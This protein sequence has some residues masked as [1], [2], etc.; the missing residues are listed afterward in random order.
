MSV[1]NT[2]HSEST[3]KKKVP[4]SVCP[5]CEGRLVDGNCETVCKG[6][7]LVIETEGIDHGPEW[8]A[9]NSQDRDRK[10]RVGAPVTNTMHDKG[11]STV[12]S[13]SDKD[14]QGNLLSGRKRRQMRRLRTWNQR[15]KTGGSR[16]QYQKQ[17]FGEIER[18]A[19]ALGLP[20]DVRET[21]CV[22]FRRSHDEGLVSGRS[23]ESVAAG[24]LHIAATMVGLP[25]SLDEITHV[26]RVARIPIARAKREII[27]E[28]ELAVQPGD[29]TAFLDRFG[30]QLEQTDET[31]RMARRILKTA[32]DEYLGSGASPVAIAASAL[33]LSDQLTHGRSVSQRAV[34]EVSGVCIATIQ[35]HHPTL[36]ENLEEVSCE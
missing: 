26:A 6:C 8:R 35:K 4:K 24:T 14:S 36:Q 30:S 3:N 15:S 23:I 27:C 20:Q 17:A 31:I 19:S 10:S 34:S 32:P 12:I 21:A 1:R 2:E 9:F 11:L 29:P 16:S 25:R 13:Y 5:E 22:L 28:F 7:G 33:Y 18:M